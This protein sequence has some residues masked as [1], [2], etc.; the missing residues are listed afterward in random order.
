[1]SNPQSLSV[2]IE[3][4]VMG[5]EVISGTLDTTFLYHSDQLVAGGANYLIEVTRQGKYTD[6]PF[7]YFS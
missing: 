6:N 2:H 4:R 1:M 5:V 7:F 3:N